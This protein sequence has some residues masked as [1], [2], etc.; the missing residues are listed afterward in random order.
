MSFVPDARQLKGLSYAKASLYGMPHLGCEYTADDVN[1][2]R[3]L[4]GACCVVCGRPY[5][6]AHHE[7]PK[8]VGRN[9]LLSTP[10]GQFVLKPALIALCGSG[11]TG[12]H[13]MRHNGQLKVRW[14]WYSD[15]NAERWWDG[16]W[17]SHGYQPHSERL[18]ELGRYVFEMDGTEREARILPREDRSLTCSS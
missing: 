4:E 14:E 1:R 2:Y 8:G 18:F 10:M 12:C 7:P 9:F 5:P 15:E 13:G 16:Y 11:T 3:T 6:N 17:L